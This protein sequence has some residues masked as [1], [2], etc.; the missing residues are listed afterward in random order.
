MACKRSSVR[1]RLAPP[2]FFGAVPYSARFFLYHNGEV[3]VKREQRS[4]HKYRLAE[5][6]S[7]CVRSRMQ[8]YIVLFFLL[9]LSPHAVQS[10]Q[11]PTAIETPDTAIE[12]GITSDLTDLSTNRDII[13]I[14]LPNNIDE[15]KLFDIVTVLGSK[16]NAQPQN[17]SIQHGD[18]LTIKDPGIGILLQLPVVPR[19]A[20]TLPLSP[21]IETLAR[22]NTQINI[23]Y[24]ITGPFKY[25]GYE[26]Y[27][28]KDIKVAFDEPS[29]MPGAFPVAIYGAS[30]TVINQ[31][32]VTSKMPDIQP[33]VKQKSNW[34]WPWIFGILIIGMV[35]ATMAILT[36][37]YLPRLKAWAKGDSDSTEGEQK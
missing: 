21:F 34:I 13:S 8:F 25:I 16:F 29:L 15:K 32:L 14:R 31:Q 4:V 10:Q 22:E 24:I 33:P 7:N 17:V 9:A 23:V 20:G 6:G 37:I 12:I 36:M 28:D 35:S 1:S 18:P 19:G 30:I 26:K 2:L 11:P 27:E 3:P 5:M